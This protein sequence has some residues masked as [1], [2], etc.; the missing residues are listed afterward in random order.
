M[1]KKDTDLL[2]EIG[3]LRKV[4]RAWQQY[5]TPRVQNIAEHT[6][7]TALIGWV[8]ATNE[9]ADTSKVIK[10]C[11]LHDLAESRTGDI[12]FSHRPYVDRHEQLAE[13]HMFKDTA[14]EKEARILLKEYSE[15][16]SKESQIARDADNL[17]VD[18]EL[19]E[20]VRIG[21][22]SAIRMRRD[23]QSI[24]KNKKLYSKTA[25]KIW[26]EIQKTDPDSWYT[27]LVTTWLKSPKGAK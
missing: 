14:L 21:D 19:K 5:L 12:A 22:T 9:G 20:L 11:L 26:D 25:K 27:T 18:L 10:M 7:R 3:T 23:R 8:I 24:I 2:F 13:E 15:R 1:V 6:F 17:D 16:K 4:P